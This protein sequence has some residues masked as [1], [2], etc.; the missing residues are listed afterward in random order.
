MPEKLKLLSWR[1][2]LTIALPSLLL[3]RSAHSGWLRS[4]SSRHRP[5]PW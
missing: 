2:I 4:S 1:D 3:A 5:T